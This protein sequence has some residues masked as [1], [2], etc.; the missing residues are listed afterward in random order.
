MKNLAWMNFLGINSLAVLFV[1]AALCIVAG[2][3]CVAINYFSKRG[4]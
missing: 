2:F 1:F 4:K 3:V